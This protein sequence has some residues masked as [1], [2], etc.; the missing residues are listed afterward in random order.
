MIYADVYRFMYIIMKQRFKVEVSFESVPII[1]FDDP[2]IGYMR[3]IK[4]PAHLYHLE[5]YYSGFWAIVRHNKRD[6]ISVS[7]PSEAHPQAHVSAF[8][9]G[10]IH[11]KGFTKIRVKAL[12][13]TTGTSRAKSYGVKG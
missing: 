1:R 11:W 10:P 4:V 2:I 3:D 8:V 5:V 13:I 12:F 9:N 7:D 6:S